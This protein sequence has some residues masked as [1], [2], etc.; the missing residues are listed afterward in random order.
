MRVPEIKEA[1]MKLSR[2]EL[3]DLVKWLDEFSQ[4]LWDKQ[5]EEDLE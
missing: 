3:T 4:S 5:I 1:V 2:E